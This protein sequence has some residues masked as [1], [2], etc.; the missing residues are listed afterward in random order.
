VNKPTAIPPDLP[1]PEEL[2]ITRRPDGEEFVILPPAIEAHLAKFPLTSDFWYISSGHYPKAA[3]LW[4][5]R[6]QGCVEHT[7]IYCTAGKAKV[8]VGGK[9]VAL[10]P[11]EFLLMPP[12]TP[13]AYGPDENDPW[14]IHWV[15]FGGVK[16]QEYH[17]QRPAN[18]FVLPVA[19]SCRGEVE[20]LFTQLHALLRESLSDAHLV[21]ASKLVEHLLG[22]LLLRNHALYDAAPHSDDPVPVAVRFMRDNLYHTVTLE[23]LAKATHLSVPHFARLFRR[24]MGSAPLDYF[25]RLKMQRACQY[26]DTTDQPIK[27]IARHLGYADACYFTRVFKRVMGKTPQAYRNAV[28]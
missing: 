28:A 9:T 19:E 22:V 8:K 23:D 26:L 18:Q 10:R 20:Q 15:S 14:S 27:V 21:C 13:H 17:R 5:D 11:G 3:A 25:I 12:H 1:L 7:L 2:Q 16:A 4:R 24:R 6:P